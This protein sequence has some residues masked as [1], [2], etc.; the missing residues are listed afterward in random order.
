GAGGGGGGGGGARGGG[1]AGGSGGGGFDG[2][3]GGGGGGGR[4][5]GEV[6][7]P[8]NL[9]FGVSV[10]NLLNNVNFG[11]PVGS[12]TSPSFGIPRNTSGG[13]NGGSANRRIEL[14]TRFTFY[15]SN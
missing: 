6:R 8:Y 10:Q 4:A 3:G 9:S 5:P 2:G 12:L 1:R 7:K 13:F 11:Q 14:T 15:S